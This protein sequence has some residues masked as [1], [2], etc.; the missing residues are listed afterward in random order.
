MT[1]EKLAREGRAWDVVDVASHPFEPLGE[2]PELPAD[3]RRLLEAALGQLELRFFRSEAMGSISRLGEP[4][5]AFRSRVLASLRPEVQYRVAAGRD[6]SG[7]GDGLPAAISRVGGGFEE[8]VV[9]ME[10][11]HV[12]S[13]S[14]GIV[15]VP[16]G[17]KLKGP[18]AWDDMVRG[19]VRPGS[20]T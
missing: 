4:L 18:G 15:L 3:V 2:G 1:T 5:A 13:A 10:P 19:P 6:G 8:V 20:R 17:L 11:G 14:L 12:R 9:H 16:R 7:T